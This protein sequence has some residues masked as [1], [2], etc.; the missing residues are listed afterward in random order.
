MR[1]ARRETEDNRYTPGIIPADAGSTSKVRTV[2]F[3]ARDH[4]RG[5]GE[6]AVALKAPSTLCGSSPRMRGALHW[7]DDPKSV[8]GIIPADA[9]ST[10]LDKSHQVHHR[11]HPR[12]CG[13]HY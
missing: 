4:P 9:G 1:G 13:E 5:C 7:W 6:H 11:D 8:P 2:V 12:G 3:P 10:A